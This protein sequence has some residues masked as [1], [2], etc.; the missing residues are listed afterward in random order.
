MEGQNACKL[1]QPLFL[2]VRVLA[3]FFLGGVIL[4]VLFCFSG[5]GGIGVFD[6][7]KV[8]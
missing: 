3:G 8:I 1:P 7:S 6:L 5:F 4:F 2:T